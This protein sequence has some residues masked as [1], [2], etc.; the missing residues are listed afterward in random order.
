[1][2]GLTKPAAATQSWLDVTWCPNPL[3]AASQRVMRRLP[4]DGHETLDVIVQ[5]MGLA[6]TP[7]HASLNGVPVERK[8]W[9]KKAV[10]AGDVVLLVQQAKGIEVYTAAEI[11]AKLLAASDFEVIAAYAINFAATVAAAAALN[12]IGNALFG[13]NASGNSAAKGPES[14][15][16]SG[17]ANA[18]RQYGPLPLVLGEHRLYPDYGSIPFG[19]YLYDR[20]AS[21]G[22]NGWVLTAV[23]E[24]GYTGGFTEWPEGDWEPVTGDPT[25]PYAD[26]MTVF[27]NAYDSSGTFLEAREAAIVMNRMVDTADYR[28]FC[29][30]T[31]WAAYRAS[32]AA[33]PWRDWGDSPVLWPS[34]YVHSATETTQSVYTERLTSVFNFGF[35]ALTISDLRLGSTPLAQFNGWQLDASRVVAGDPSRTQLTGYSSEGYS[36]SAY[37][38]HVQTVDGGK[39]VQNASVAN[40]GWQVRRG[41]KPASGAACNW[42]QIDVAGRLFKSGGGGI[43]ANSVQLAA[44]YRLAGA[45]TW[46]DCPF[47]PM[48]LTGADSSPVR[49]TFAFAPGTPGQIEI[50]V[51][52]V[53]AD[54]TDANRVSEFEFVRV[55]YFYADACAYPAQTRRGLLITATGQLNGRIDTLSAFVRAKHWRWTS[56]AP[57]DGMLPGD[58]AGNW[59]W[60]YTTNPAWLFLYYARGGFLNTTAAPAYLGG[61]QGWLDGE[62]AGN[63]L[64]LWGAGLA[65]ERIDYA[66]I[67]AWGQWCAAQ[68]LHCRMVVDQAQTVASVLDQIASAG[69]ASK[70]WASGKLGVVWDDAAQPVVAVF[71][72][73]NILAGS[74]QVAYD[75]DQTIDEVVL[76]YTDSSNDYQ[77][78]ASVRALVPGVTTASNPRNDRA[79]YSMAKVQA[80]RLVNIEA[81]RRAYQP[82]HVVW[83]AGAEG[84]LVARGD[85]VAVSHD[86]TSW[87]YSGR[88]IAV[89]I[90]S[91][92]VASVTL[93]RAVLNPDDAEVYYLWVR[94]PDGA[95]LSVACA[96]PEGGSASTLTVT[97]A[98]SEEHA[99]GRT[100]QGGSGENEASNYPDSIPQDWQFFAGATAT[101]G[102]RLRIVAVEP[103]AP[104]EFRI[105]AVDHVPELLTAA[106]DWDGSEEPATVPDLIGT[107]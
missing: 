16:V 46:I 31:E 42:V 82:R 11:T 95:M 9:H 79:P 23:V 100:G 105:T 50:R 65:N 32:G 55:K 29:T 38:T 92:W 3:M 12:A 56:D 37:P 48:D 86:L 36:G 64:R 51:R 47:S 97:G 13:K 20:D 61:A 7:L 84:M 88:L 78:G 5:R 98:W 10:R 35:G 8:R 89:S 107:D 14:F 30:G 70:T 34:T 102:K 45:D 59:A 43:E 106:E 44:Q 75:T 40:F 68:R 80:Q 17:G 93:S 27:Y 22:S 74:F 85:V 49:R 63:G 19:E 6:A 101:P 15:S 52:R 76:D 99:P 57:W 66:A 83:Q 90:D 25:Y 67:V 33:P 72:M 60:G 103:G 104:R 58:G 41:A 1:M 18:V 81:A 69:R 62:G 73:G 2:P 54:E 96:P 26:Q 39:L 94:K 87:A 53:T 24:P 77:A 91:G 28:K 4:L 71:G 21:V